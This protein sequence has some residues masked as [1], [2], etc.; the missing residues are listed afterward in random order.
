MGI[1]AKC[2]RLLAVAAIMALLARP[3]LA[4]TFAPIG[5]EQAGFDPARLTR[6]DSFL[7]AAVAE[8]RMPGFAVLLARHGRLVSLKIFLKKNLATG[9]PIAPDTIF[10]IASMSKLVTGVALMILFEENKFAL[11]DPVAKFIPEFAQ[12]KVYAGVD[13]AGRPVLV[14]PAHPPTMRELMSHSAGFGY[15]TTDNPADTMFASEKPFSAPNLQAFVKR[16][17]QAPL[18]DQPGTTWR[19]SA[20]ADISGYLIEKLSGMR[21]GEFLQQRLFG[22]LGMKDSGFYVPAGK[23]P[24]LAPAYSGDPKTGRF[25]E[26]RTINSI[27]LP[28]LAPTSPPG[29]ESGGGGL[30]ST[31]TDY[32]RFAQMLANGGELDGFRI[33]SPAT[34]EMMGTNMLPAK[35]LEAGI[36]RPPVH[37]DSNI[38]FGLDAQIMLNP[39]AAGSL[40]GK[41][42]M[43]WHGAYAGWVWVDRANDIICVGMAQ[44]L[45]AYPDYVFDDIDQVQTLVY[46]A[47]IHPER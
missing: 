46:Q 32:A 45:G 26:V 14:D 33:L 27:G 22:P 30:F 4:E 8:G 28:N 9:E 24:R 6:L 44:R 13:A 21:F 17:S 16:V 2:R 7:D 43:S 36:P 34:I 41:G 35:A 12:L 25:V 37:F 38:G 19:Y 1:P 3:A 39:R 40:V 11:D 31:V 29:L 47:L 5:A 20:Q 18:I 15:G 10:R 42:T 23:L